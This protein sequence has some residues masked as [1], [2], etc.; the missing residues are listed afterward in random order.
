MGEVGNLKDFNVSE[1]KNKLLNLQKNIISTKNKISI[2]DETASKNDTAQSQDKELKV[3]GI[4]DPFSQGN[5][6]G[7]CYFV[8]SIDAI[9]QDEDGKE[10][11]KDSI[12][13]TSN[14]SYQV[15]F[16]KNPDK[17]IP[18]SMNEIEQ[19]RENKTI[20]TG[21]L[22][23]Q[24]L[25]VAGNKTIDNFSNGGR[26]NEAITLLTGQECEVANQEDKIKI[27]LD[28]AGSDT[29]GITMAVNFKQDVPDLGLVDKH[30]YSVTDVQKPS[31]KNQDGKIALHN[32]HDTGKEIVLTYDQFCKYTAD[33]VY[34]E[35]K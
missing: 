35:T 31:S 21:D 3:D 22:D 32:P 10:I 1:I 6:I 26:S 13:K 23:V 2:F 15:T 29:D 28:K 24:I 8:G 34:Q 11:V 25:E 17:K 20:S 16:G 19:R 30:T 33:L 7:N 27:L 14:G 18:V 9:S 5:K 12:D 4:I